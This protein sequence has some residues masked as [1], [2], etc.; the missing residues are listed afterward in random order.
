MEIDEE[1]QMNR[2]GKQAANNS[3]GGAA[4]YKN[5]KAWQVGMQVTTDIYELTKQFPQDER[6]GLTS[7]SPANQRSQR[8]SELAN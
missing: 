6:Y 2:R 5:N 4:G 7:R 8:I 3:A 1:R